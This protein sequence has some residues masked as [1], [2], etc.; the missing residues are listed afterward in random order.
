[1]NYAEIFGGIMRKNALIVWKTRWII[2]KFQ[3]LK[4]FRMFRTTLQSFTHSL[5]SLVECTSFSPA[6]TYA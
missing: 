3:K 5:S 2:G 1:M 6:L 4:A